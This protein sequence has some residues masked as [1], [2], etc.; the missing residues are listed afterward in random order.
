M[1]LDH[2]FF[3][4]WSLLALLVIAWL[5]FL[6]SKHIRKILLFHSMKKELSNSITPDIQE[7]LELEKLAKNKGSGIKL[8]SILGL[9]KF[10]SV[11][12]NKADKEDPLSSLLLRNFSAS[13]ELRKLPKEK[14][15]LLLEVINS[16]NFGTLALRFS[17]YGTLRGMQP[18]LPFFFE[19]IELSLAETVIF[20]RVLIIPD[21]KNRPFFTLVG[22]GESREWLS[23]RGRG[24]GLAL[25]IISY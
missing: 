12:K 13:L 20:K 24:G 8:D 17:G 11:W 22:I 1:D 7:L 25:W 4:D 15:G 5:I 23:A 14:D 19:S 2:Y 18:K 6:Y 21:E 10:K 16:I 3:F 9:W